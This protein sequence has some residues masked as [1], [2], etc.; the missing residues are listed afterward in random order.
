MKKV[1]KT[2]SLYLSLIS[3]FIL[4]SSCVSQKKIEYLQPD[5]RDS[6]T[7]VTNP[8]VMNTTIQP[9]DELF[10]QVYSFDTNTASGSFNASLSPYSAA[11]LSYTVNKEGFIIYPL[12]GEVKLEGL[13]L[14]DAENQIKKQLDSY[15]NHP[16]VN[17]KKVNTNVSVIGYVA[18][19]G[20][21]N[22]SNAK[23]NVFQAL[24]LAGDITDYGDRK[25]VY[26]LRTINDKVKTITIDLTKSDVPLSPYFYL[27]SNDVV[28]VRPL[29]ARKW[30][31]LNFP[32]AFTLLL[33]S[34]STTALLINI[35]K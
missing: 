26:I 30:G 10:I 9:G 32:V 18:H 2:S 34:I 8:A 33:S 20:N 22:Y 13:T 14:S 24:S 27:E 25:N 35:L 21:F 29:H 7:E 5:N 19:P 1:T 11:I 17:I 23:L 15:L 4:Y 12:L 3:F 31:I 28:Y 6:K 16:S